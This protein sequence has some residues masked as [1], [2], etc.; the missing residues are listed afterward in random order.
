MRA[1]KA[2]HGSLARVCFRRLRAGEAPR[3][4]LLYLAESARKRAQNAKA[5]LEKARAPPRSAAQ[6]RGVRRSAACW[7]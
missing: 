1:S 6:C 2:A 4:K 5:A 3:E 7:M